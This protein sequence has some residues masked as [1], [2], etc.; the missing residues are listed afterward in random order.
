MNPEMGRQIIRL[1]PEIGSIA[2]KLKSMNLADRQ[3][4]TEKV[5][6]FIIG[7]SGKN[8]AELVGFISRLLYLINKE[9]DLM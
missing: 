5:L 9:L 6:L 4:Y 7:S 2:E 1:F 3:F 8:D